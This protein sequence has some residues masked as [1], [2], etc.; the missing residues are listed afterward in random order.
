MSNI[1]MVDD[2]CSPVKYISGD[3]NNDSKLDLN[4]TWTYTCSTMLSATK[5]NTVVATGW[6]NGVS[7]TDIAS[8]TVIVGS[9]VVPPLIHVTKVPSPL[10]LPA[11][12]GIVTYTKK[13]TNPGMIALSNVTVADDKCSPVKYISG[14]T[15]NDSKLDPSETWTYTCQMNLTK[16]TTNTLQQ[17]VKLMA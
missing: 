10:A 9:P 14:D 13:V 1:T 5:T 2:S 6:Y 4:E 17:P 7:A 3:T 16:T 15:N 11:G 12:G 8:A